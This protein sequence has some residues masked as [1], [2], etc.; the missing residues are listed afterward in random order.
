MRSEDD[1]SIM[2]F[3]EMP[4]DVPPTHQKSLGIEGR[5]WDTE[6]RSWGTEY[7]YPWFF[8]IITSKDL[9]WIFKENLQ[10][11]FGVK[12]KIDC[13]YVM[14]HTSTV[15]SGQCCYFSI[16]FSFS[17]FGLNFHEMYKI[18]RAG[19]EYDFSLFR[20]R[21]P[22]C[23]GTAM[24]CDKWEIILTSFT[25]HFIPIFCISK[26]CFYGKSQCWK[27]ENWSERVVLYILLAQQWISL[28]K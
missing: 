10:T 13:E 24:W 3:V 12:G 26:K 9:L 17:M 6:V 18:S 23:T 14:L 8:A 4:V 19:C 15:F 16:C 27:V 21:M 22:G 20:I 11:E 25:C 5:S 1:I 28:T 7:S 2:S